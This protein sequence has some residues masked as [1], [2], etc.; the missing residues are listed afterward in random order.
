M[1]GGKAFKEDCEGDWASA[2]GT[3]PMKFNHSQPVNEISKPHWGNV[4]HTL[5]G[6]ISRL[7][8][9]DWLEQ[10]Q[11]ASLGDK[12]SYRAVTYGLILR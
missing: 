7:R 11:I 3:E 9:F 10:G 2:A 12:L 5:A 1:W 4:T 8:S 6:R